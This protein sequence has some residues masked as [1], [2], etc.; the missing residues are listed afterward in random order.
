MSSNVQQ[1]FLDEPTKLGD[2]LDLEL[3]AKLC[4]AIQ[5][6]MNLQWLE[7]SYGQSFGNSGRYTHA[8]YW[9]LISEVNRRGGNVAAAEVALRAIS[10]KWRDANPIVDPYEDEE[11]GRGKWDPA[12]DAAFDIDRE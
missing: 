2:L 6:H 1:A 8:Q 4:L 12:L 3:I 10:K 9:E 11:A 7:F 5:K